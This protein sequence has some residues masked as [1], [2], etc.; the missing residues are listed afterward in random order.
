MTPIQLVERVA[1]RGCA[2]RLI[3]GILAQL[4][5][6][7]DITAFCALDNVRTYLVNESHKDLV[8]ARKN[9]TL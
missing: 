7:N 3:D 8:D 1:N 5:Y 9:W 2:V 6:K 4:Y